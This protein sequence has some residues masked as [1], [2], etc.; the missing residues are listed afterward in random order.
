MG[1][2]H[3]NKKDYSVKVQPIALAIKNEPA[4]Y[5]FE[6][7]N[8]VLDLTRYKLDPNIIEDIGWAFAKVIWRKRNEIAAPT[9]DLIMYAIDRFYEFLESKP[10]ITKVSDLDQTHINDFIYWLKNVATLRNSSG[11]P[12]SESSKRRIWGYIRESLV[13]FIEED[14]TLQDIELPT[15][16]FDANEGIPFKSYSKN[17]LNQI[18]KASFKE[19]REV[20]NGLGKR[21]AFE[22][23]YVRKLIPHAIQVL[24]KTGINPEVLFDMD[25][26]SQSIKS[27]HI[28]N[29]SRLILPVKKRS[30]KSQN[31][32][33]LDELADGVRIKNDVVRLLE[34]VENLTSELRQSLPNESSL[35]Q[36]L[37]LVKD[38]NGKIDMFNNF[39]YYMSLQLFS[40]R[41]NILDDSGNTLVINF[42]RFRP[43]FAEQILKINGGNLRDL[44]KRLGHSHI[45]TTMGY[46]DPNL[47][48]RK[49]SFHYAGQAMVNWALKEEKSPSLNQISE[50]LEISQDDANKL[51]K[52]EFN[53]T[54]G[55]CKNP[56]DSPLKGVKKGEFC[57]QY[58]A[59]FRCHYSVILKED[60]HR[61]FSF[62]HWL[63]S[64][65]LVLGEQKWQESYGWIIEIIDNEIA[66][67]LGD[68]DWISLMKNEAE[69]NPF[70]MWLRDQ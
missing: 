42:R 45:R 2:P 39:R 40:K 6:I 50:K 18:A 41:N 4:S 15:Q 36:K 56:F 7:D 70:P 27:S 34:Q 29:S 69:K 22:S 54:V 19:S 38:D 31:I 65:R 30:G 11:E 37:W 62:Y 5:L 24:I 57:T 35:K 23:G 52:G 43:T 53:V 67:K 44:Q 21:R 61:L 33:L 68:S 28:L 20:V 9:T 48:E 51:I 3:K 66:P 60:G 10:K 46:L 25:I 16:V 55:K 26:T 63:K 59:C 32:E 14:P 47:D 17:E 49:E 64:K 12:L 13:S 58:L 1:K 8:K